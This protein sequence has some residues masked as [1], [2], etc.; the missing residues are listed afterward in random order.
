MGKLL[1][2]RLPSFTC[3]HQTPSGPPIASSS[4]GVPVRAFS[5]PRSSSPPASF[6]AWRSN[7]LAWAE[8]PGHRGCLPAIEASGLRKLP[9]GGSPE[10]T[11]RLKT[12][13]NPKFKFIRGRSGRDAIRIELPSG[14]VGFVA[15]TIPP[16]AL[17]AFA[18]SLGRKLA[19]RRRLARAACQTAS[20]S[21]RPPLPSD[22]E[23]SGK[24]G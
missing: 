8:P 7:T 4:A 1:V 14:G 18:T 9:S 21:T 15:T 24:V 13:P 23:V 17:T 16:A 5:R 22:D 12:P 11:K 10:M 20:P 6:W 3:S 19:K 2:P